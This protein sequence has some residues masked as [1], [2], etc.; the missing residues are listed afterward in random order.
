MLPT[1][2]PRPSA[3]KRGYGAE[4]AKARRA[5]LSLQPWCEH[6]LAKGRSR[7]ATD[8]DHKTPKALGGSDEADNL[9]SLC[10]PCH[11]RKTAKRDGAFGRERKQ[12]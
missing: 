6:C 10:H 9:Q 8:V 11:S 5:Q 4:W 1:T 2:R 7:K 12:S 3:A